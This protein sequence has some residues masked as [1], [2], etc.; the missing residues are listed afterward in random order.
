MSKLISAINIL[1]GKENPNTLPNAV[2]SRHARKINQLISIDAFL[3]CEV[4]E[5]GFGRPL[6][7]FYA[8]VWV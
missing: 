2:H 5:E 4:G 3:Y 8:L 7:F 1:V 6:D